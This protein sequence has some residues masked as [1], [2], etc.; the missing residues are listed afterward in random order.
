MMNIIRADIY[1]IVRGKG[2]FITFA[3][4]LALNILVV[5]TSDGGTIGINMG[6][7][8][9]ALGYD[10]AEAQ[11]DGLHIVEVLYTNTDNLAY[12]LLP[13][14]IL[15]A[16]PMFSHG[17]IKNSL[18]CGMS[19]VKLYFAK[20][21]LSSGLSL[22]MLLFYI[23]SGILIATIIRGYGGT[24]PDGYLLNILKICSAQFFLLL[25]LNCVGIFL[26]FISQRT[27]AVIGIYLA[28]CLVPA[29]IIMF[30][31]GAN[32]DAIKLYDFDLLGNIQ[33]LGHMGALKRPDFIKAFA[34]GTFYI[35]ASTIGG[36]AL[37]KRAEIK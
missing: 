26:I 21:L 32:P 17:T 36:I 13:L 15:V 24:P 29:L 4:L 3:I 11:F 5:A 1:R 30:L 14:F 23:L 33:K 9:E 10:Y 27:A 2:I 34:T 31:M 35:V 16:A 7:L 19:R 12:Y 22:L 20:L 25:A 6:E 37:F 28:F 18:S 8:E